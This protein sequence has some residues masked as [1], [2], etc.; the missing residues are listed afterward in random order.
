MGGIDQR[1]PAFSEALRHFIGHD[2]GRLT[3]A[4]L[5]EEGDNCGNYRHRK[6][7]QSVE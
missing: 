2:W 1:T 6:W 7:C 3:A 5:L 4:L